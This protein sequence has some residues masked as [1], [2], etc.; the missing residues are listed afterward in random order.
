MVNNLPQFRQIDRDHLV[1]IVCHSII[2]MQ[3]DL[4]MHIQQM[5]ELSAID[6]S[7]EE[8]RMMWFIY[9]MEIVKRIT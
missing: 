6:L 1:R 5:Y 9:F 2:L 8:C 3:I 7:P 4:Y